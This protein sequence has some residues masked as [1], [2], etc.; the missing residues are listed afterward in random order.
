MLLSLKKELS[1]FLDMRHVWLLHMTEKAW[2]TRQER[3]AY[4]PFPVLKIY[5]LF[6]SIPSPPKIKTISEGNTLA[7]HN[8]YYKYIFVLLSVFKVIHTLLG[9]RVKC[10]LPLCSWGREGKNLESSSTSVKTSNTADSRKSVGSEICKLY[11]QNE[12][13]ITFFLNKKIFLIWQSRNQSQ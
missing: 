13:Q 1:Y 7:S 2:W 12:P 8:K 4:T 9:S 5:F 10:N 6:F 11:K 3:V